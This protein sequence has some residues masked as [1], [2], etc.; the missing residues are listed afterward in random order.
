[1]KKT[2]IFKKM[3]YITSAFVL[4]LFAVFESTLSIY[5]KAEETTAE[6]VYSNVLDDLKKDTNFNVEDYPAVSNDYSV[7]LITI[8][9][10][11]KNDLFLYVYQPSSA[12]IDL[13]CIK[14]SISLGFSPDGQDL[15]PSL[16]TLE[17]VS[18]E[19]VFDKYLV[20]DIP[21][22]NEETHYYNIVSLYRVFNA[23]IDTSVDSGVTNG[24]AYPVGEQWSCYI[25][26]GA[27]VYE[28][29]TFK[30]VKLTPTL[31]G[32]VFYEDGFTFSDLLGLDE[33]CNSHFLA[34][35]VDGIID[36]GVLQTI[37]VRHIYDADLTYEYRRARSVTTL[38]NGI[39]QNTTMVLPDGESYK[40]AK[41]TLTDTQARTYKGKGLC[42]KEYTWKRI[43]TSD[44]FISNYEDQG[45]EL[46]E[47]SKEAI[48]KSQYVFCFAET[49]YT[50][51]SKTNSI[52]HDYT[53]VSDVTVLR[54]HFMDTTG[55]VYNLGVVMDI[56]TSDD[57]ADG[58]AKP[59][60]D[61]DG[62]FTEMLEMLGILF[63]FIILALVLS[64]V[65]PLIMPLLRGLIKG[66]WWIIC[67]PFNVIGKLFKK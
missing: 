17:L 35:N 48:E 41:V 7:S 23:L 40:S 67:F 8:A 24:K 25:E 30:T 59:D 54:L 31:N 36:N 55:D 43:M 33:S 27:Y 12:T 16:Y 47:T 65:M 29:C 28:K 4:S 15:S 22:V 56:T 42:A 9:E 19:G 53:Q 64:I 57:I 50:T 32:N 44:E 18:T 58:T 11:V 14:V 46:N 1:M 5:A 61:L 34:F 10:G 13:P 51:L 26:D 60:I 66:L 63:G 21:R 3:I 2:T 37:D 39:P 52:T 20:K 38:Y 6:T 62:F 45:G 49:G